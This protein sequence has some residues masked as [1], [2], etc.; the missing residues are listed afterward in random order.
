MLRPCPVCQSENHILIFRDH[1]R[2][3]KYTELEA[4][5]VKCTSCG[6]QFLTEIPSFESMEGKYEEIYVEPDLKALSKKL[7]PHPVI[8]GKKILDIGCNHGTQL[9]PAYNAGWEVFGIDLNAHAIK[10]CR[11]YLPTENFDVTTVDDV[12]FP[13]GYFDKI[14]TFHVLEHVY[15]PISFLKK[16]YLLLKKGAELEIRIPNWGSLEMKVWGKYSSQSWVPFHINMFNPTT[17]QLVLEKAGFTDIR[18]STNPIPWWWILSFRQWRGTI[19]LKKGVTNF[20]QNIFHKGLQVVLYP[21]LYV[22][23]LCHLGEELHVHAYK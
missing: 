9:I 23:A 13:N 19:N 12:K 3:E 22:V 5:F 7:A 11:K 20:H 16:S 1:N 17:I 18:I 21:I 10:D 4:D 8:N 2:R 6:M 15:D 14:Q